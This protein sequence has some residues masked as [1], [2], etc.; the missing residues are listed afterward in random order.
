MKRSL[1]V[2]KDLSIPAKQVY[3]DLRYE[4]KLSIEQVLLRGCCTNAPMKATQ[5]T[6]PN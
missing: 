5:R 3:Q 4:L 1:G 2:N 6:S